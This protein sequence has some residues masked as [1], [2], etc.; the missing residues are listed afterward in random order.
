MSHIPKELRY[1][2]SH[3]W[4]RYEEGIATVG[5]TDHAQALLGDVVFVELPDIDI[6]VTVG[7]EAGVVESVKAAS[8]IYAPLSGII[9]EVNSALADSPSLLNQDPYNDAWIFKLKIDD[10]AELD[11]LLDA[12]A[13]E[14]LVNDEEH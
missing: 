8:D 10:F 6:E 4:V 1:S 9:V 14:V 2:R 11:D 13:Y 7:D 3:E 5:I 12:A